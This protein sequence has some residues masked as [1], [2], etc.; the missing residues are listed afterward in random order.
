MHGRPLLSKKTF[1]PDTAGMIHV[2][3]YHALFDLSS[4]WQ[5]SG[6]LHKSHPLAFGGKLWYHNS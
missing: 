4:G 2:L 6:T 5:D 3:L 1:T